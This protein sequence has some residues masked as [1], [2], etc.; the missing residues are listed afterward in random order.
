M[1]VKKKVMGY[2]ANCRALFDKHS[3]SC[4]RNLPLFCDPMVHYHGHYPEYY[5]FS[6]HTIFLYNI[7]I[8]IASIV[9]SGT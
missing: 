5:K 3:L 8:Y 9:P 1:P 6:A 2:I 4:S 7:Y